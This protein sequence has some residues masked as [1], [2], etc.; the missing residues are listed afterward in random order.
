MA[1]SITATISAT[2]MG[3][4]WADDYEAA[5]AFAAFLASKFRAA[6]PAAEIRVQAHRS[7]THDR[8]TT[9]VR[10]DGA[11]DPDTERRVLNIEQCAWRMFCDTDQA[12]RLRRD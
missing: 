3:P 6:F 8:D 2:N 12:Q 5:Q 9:S 1:I 7:S 11:M 4:E 10:N